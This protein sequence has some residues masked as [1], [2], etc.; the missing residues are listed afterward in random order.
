MGAACRNMGAGLLWEVKG[1]VIW[2]AEAVAEDG[3]DLGFVR[4]EF[5]SLV[6]P[7]VELTF[8]RHVS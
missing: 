7:V 6:G 4:S 1:T 5:T 3:E 2:I 8:F